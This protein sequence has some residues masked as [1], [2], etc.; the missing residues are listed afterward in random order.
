MH[1]VSLQ[2]K[3]ASETRFYKYNSTRQ[4]IQCFPRC[5]IFY[6]IIFLAKR[7]DLHLLRTVN[8]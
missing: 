6:E 5:V 7:L 1:T 8:F 3:L 2:L 4:M